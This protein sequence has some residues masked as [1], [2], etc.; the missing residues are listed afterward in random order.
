M[1]R[2][3]ST[4][5]SSATGWEPAGQ[6]CSRGCRAWPG[7]SLSGRN[8]FTSRCE[9]TPR[10]RGRRSGREGLA[11]TLDRAKAHRAPP[12]CPMRAGVLVDRYDARFACD[13]GVVAA[14]KPQHRRESTC[15]SWRALRRARHWLARRAPSRGDRQA[16]PAKDCGD[17]PLPPV[18]Q[19]TTRPRRPAHRVQRFDGLPSTG[20]ASRSSW[21]GR[22]P[23]FPA[24]RVWAAQ[25]LDDGG[26]RGG[27]GR[28][29]CWRRPRRPSPDRGRPRRG[30][31]S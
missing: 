11:T 10:S 25:R 12:T 16:R 28:R 6:A 4:G 7:R 20:T 9:Q 5:R 19:L 8:S 17:G 31:G 27:E 14:P 24:L 21:P 15:S 26:N 22:P 18:R 29:P 13:H 2:S 30:A 3:R 23:E 1:P